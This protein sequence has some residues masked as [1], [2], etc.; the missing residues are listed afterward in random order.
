[1]TNLRITDWSMFTLDCLKKFAPALGEGP[2]GFMHMEMGAEL[3]DANGLEM[4][5]T[6]SA[7]F[8][9]GTH[10]SASCVMRQRNGRW[11][12]GDMTVEMLD[13]NGRHTKNPFKYRLS[14]ERLK[15][16]SI[17]LTS[18]FH[19]AI[20]ADELVKVSTTYRKRE[21]GWWSADITLNEVL[22]LCQVW[23]NLSIRKRAN[24]VEEVFRPEEKNNH[25]S[26]ALAAGRLCD[27]QKPETCV[28]RLDDMQMTALIK[29][30]K[31]G[32]FKKYS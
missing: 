6:I 26:D 17:L 10:I 19:R 28:Q 29:I 12:L 32:K 22:S 16:E 8:A 4:H 3:S 25:W 27:L 31:E 13:A 2:E 15:D 5:V 30:L 24:I 11:N 23:N 20:D 7:L 21:L 14:C 1:M 9:S 18:F